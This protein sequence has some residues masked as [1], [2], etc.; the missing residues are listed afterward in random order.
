MPSGTSVVIRKHR[1]K[2]EIE[3]VPEVAVVRT[4]EP[5]TFEV[6][7][8]NGWDPGTRVAITFH[9]EYRVGPLVR[10]RRAAERRGPFRHKKDDAASP[11]QGKF[12]VD[13]AGSVAT[14]EVEDVPM[15]LF[16][17]LWKYDVSWTGLPDLDPMI[18]IEKGG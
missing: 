4:G 5:L 3:V 11:E 13:A 12:V 1:D 18:K 10:L 9:R 16:P 17:R 15:A 8:E 7:K 14:G 6:S 2:N